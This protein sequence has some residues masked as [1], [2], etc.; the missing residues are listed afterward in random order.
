MNN[1]KKEKKKGRMRTIII[2][3]KRLQHKKGVGRGKGNFKKGEK[4]ES[5]LFCLFED[6]GCGVGVAHA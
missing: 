6:H 4:E 5:S 3:V 1:G 2:T